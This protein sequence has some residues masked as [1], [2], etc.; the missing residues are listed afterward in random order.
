MVIKRT[1]SK[2]YKLAEGHTEIPGTHVMNLHL[3]SQAKPLTR[4]TTF[5]DATETLPTSVSI[6]QA[7]LLKA[8]VDGHRN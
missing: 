6:L 4:K 3:K 2:D 5:L 1:G 8:M 7:A